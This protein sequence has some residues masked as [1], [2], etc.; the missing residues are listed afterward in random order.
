VPSGTEEV[1]LPPLGVAGP[2]DRQVDDLA[3]L[4]AVQAGDDPRTPMAIP[5]DGAAFAAPLDR[6]VRGAR[7]GWLGD[8]DGHFPLESGVL[9]LC[10][11]ALRTLEGLGCV[12]E[13]ARP[14]FDPEAV[15]RAWLTLRAW[16]VGAN[17]RP[18]YD[19][20]AFRDLLKP[21]ARWEVEQGYGISAYDVAAASAVRTAWYHAARR[22]FERYDYLVLPSAQVFPFPVEI[23]WPKEIAGRTM[24]TYHR[25]MEVVI[26]VTMSGCP[27]ISVPVGFDGRGLPMG[28]QIVAPNRGELSLLGIAGAYE[29]ATGWVDRVLPPALRERDET[30][31]AGVGSEGATAG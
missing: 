31:Q 1:F 11:E 4:L 9:D 18:L 15:W 8:W 19:D 29:A 6:E 23:P 16:T 13:E 22:L 5:G 27:A 28:M 2:M 21:E 17:L 14:A 10:G 20:P 25:W 24:D 7:I 12:V 30:P 26:P 3:L